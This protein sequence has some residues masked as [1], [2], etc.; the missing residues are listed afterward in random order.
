MSTWVWL[1]WAV[2]AQS[3]GCAV[4]HPGTA[5]VPAHTA[6]VGAGWAKRKVKLERFWIDER[7]ARAEAYAACVKAGGCAPL[8]DDRE[9]EEGALLLDWQRADRYCAFRGK[10][11]PSEAEWEAA[12]ARELVGEEEAWTRTW[13]VTPATKCC[14]KKGET[15]EE[16]SEGAWARALCG[17]VDE[18]DACDG[19]VFCGGLGRRVV[20]RADKPTRRRG[21]SWWTDKR[22]FAARCVTDAPYLTAYPPLTVQRPRPAPPAPV[23]PTTDEVAAFRKVRRDEVEVPECE[24]VGRSYLDCRDPRSYLKTNEPLLGVVVPH[25]K[26]RGGGYTGVGSDQQYTLVAH[27]RAEWAWL[28]D[29]DE[30]VV[31]WHHVLRALVL[32]APDRRAF[33]TFFDEEGIKRAR[34]AIKARYPRR[35][36]ARELDRLW[37]GAA[38]PLADHYRTLATDPAFRWSWLGNDESY[39]WIRRLYQQD[40]MRAWLGN[41]LEDKTMGDIG[42]AARALE[43]PI[44]VYYPS[45]APEFWELTE[46]YREN[47]RGLPFDEH[48]VVVQTLSG[49]SMKTGFGQTG[50]WHYNVQHG[51]LQQRLLELPGYTRHKQLIYHRIRSESPELTLS[52]LP[53]TEPLPAP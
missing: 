43:V 21:K 6:T 52:G 12:A 3:G 2:A 41:M 19:A 29:Y 36:Q 51:L 8:P 13:L 46:Q 48:T 11:L 27:A 32:A 28:F 39:A 30:H 34:A 18:Q 45:N 23:P 49:K 5:C 4:A 10:R 9:P 24:E 38:P 31:N 17:S 26:N 15:L 22:W 35:A 7:P 16:E 1:V 20:K 53:S 40:R 37:R 50:Y 44:R 42:R 14:R 33:A 25:V 47:V